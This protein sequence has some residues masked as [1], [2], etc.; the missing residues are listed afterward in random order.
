MCHLL[1]RDREAIVGRHLSAFS[2]KERQR[3]SSEIMA[4]LEQSKAWRGLLPVLN[5]D[6]AQIDLDWSVSI[7]S[8]PDI[9]LA[10]VTDLTE[11]KAIEA[12]RE[13]LLAN[14]RLARAE[15][16]QANRMKDDFLAALS[17][18]LRTPLNAIMGYS[19]LLLLR[20]PTGDP[21]ALSKIKA[22]ER[23]A[24]V[25]AQLI[26][27][28]LDLSRI[29]SGKLQLDRQLLN[30]GDAVQAALSAIQGA[31]QARSVAILTDLEPGIEQIWWDPARFQQVVWNLIDNAVKF[32]S[33]GGEIEVRLR[34]TR[35]S[36]DLDV[37]DHGRGI[38]AHFLPHVFDRFRQQEGGSRRGYGGLGLGLA[39]VHQIVTAHGGTITAASEGSGLGATFTV[40]LPRTTAWQRDTSVEAPTEVAT[41]DLHGVRVL[42][43][44]DNDDARALTRDVLVDALANVFAVADAKSALEALSRFRPALLVSD[45]GMTEQDGYDLIR[46]VRR[47]G[48]PA[49]VLPAIALTAFARED[50][51]LRAFEAGYQAH[52]AKPLDVP[53]FLAEVCKVLGHRD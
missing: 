40:R 22:I 34:Q 17:H 20:P 35:T 39:V 51:R 49:D 1:G 3:A 16:E 13:R 43:V 52:C 42:V 14:E 6:G 45:V 11:R 48:W 30:P 10:I 33:A 28:L 27:D 23:N 25:Q 9:R 46:S 15:A 21:A 26:S 53:S 36:V 47:S 29:A 32:S 5:A 19:R 31:A 37:Q 44:E 4:A 12:E 24:Q 18:E 2:P 50:D 38:T 7:H 8:S 41:V